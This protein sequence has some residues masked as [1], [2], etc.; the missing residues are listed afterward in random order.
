MIA[1]LALKLM[2]AGLDPVPAYIS[3]WALP[4]AT[5]GVLWLLFGW[6]FV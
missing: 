6:M 1:A 3:A 5:L 4:P 2:E